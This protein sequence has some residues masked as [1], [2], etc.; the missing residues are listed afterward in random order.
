MTGTTMD[1]AS[2]AAKLTKGS[3]RILDICLVLPNGLRLSCGPRDGDP[4]TPDCTLG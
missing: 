4:L 1:A 3:D 2:T